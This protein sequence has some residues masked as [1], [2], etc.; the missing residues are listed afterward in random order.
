MRGAHPEVP[1]RRRGRGF[2]AER[3]TSAVKD[4]D[5]LDRSKGAACHTFSDLKTCKK[6]KGKAASAAKKKKKKCKREPYE[7]PGLDPNALSL[8]LDSSDPR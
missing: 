5:K 3:V 8:S 1:R 6:K 2:C 4:Y 7:L